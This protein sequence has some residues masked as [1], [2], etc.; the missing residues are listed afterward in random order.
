MRH[1]MLAVLLAA[2]PVQTA[3]RP[4]DRDITQL[5]ER[6]HQNRDRFEDQLDGKLKRNVLRGPTGEVDVERFLDDLQDNVNRLKDRFADDYAASAE[7]TAVLQQ[8]SQIHR[9]MLRQPPDLKGAS[10]WNRLAASLSELAIAY[11]TAFPLPDGATGRRMNDREV[12][13]AAEEVAE[14]ADAFKSDVAASL[15][16]KQVDEATLRAALAEVESLK[17]AARKLASRL[18]GG[19]PASGEA[20]ALIAQAAAVQSASGRWLSAAAARTAW[21]PVR[22]GLEKV[23]QGFGQTLPPLTL[24]SSPQ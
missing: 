1:T 17:T 9:F 21:M 16:A 15:K 24:T 18:D 3:E 8:G 2:F 6:V 10:E 11:G 14:A 13:Q 22:R 4:T 19:Q 23:A 20:R 5:I 12:K 7:C